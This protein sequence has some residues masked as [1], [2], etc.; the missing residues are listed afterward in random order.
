M[1]NLTSF[2]ILLV[3]FSVFAGDM[4]LNP[5]EIDEVDSYRSNLEIEYKGKKALFYMCDNYG[6][7]SEV[8]EIFKSK[9]IMAADIMK[10]GKSVTLIFNPFLKG[11]R[12]CTGGDKH[13]N[14]AEMFRIEIE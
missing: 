4:Y 7:T 6:S 10:S 11:D 1:K 13:K 8:T 2:L 9:V 5:T 14:T 3:S 12:L